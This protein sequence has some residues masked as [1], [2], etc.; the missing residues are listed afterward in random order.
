M[1][2]YETSLVKAQGTYVPMIDN[3]FQKN[4]M[5]LTSYAKQCVM[6]A[7]SEINGLIENSGKTFKDIDPRSLTESLLMVATMQLNPSATP[8]EVYFLTRNKN[9]GDKNNPNWVTQI[10]AGIEGDGNDT[11]LARFG[12]GV[13]TV[14]KFW[15]VREGDDFEYPQYM[16]IEMSP[17]KWRPSGQGKIVRIVYPISKTNGEIE[18]LIAEREDVLINLRAHIS[19]NLMNETFGIAESRYKAN[20]AQKEK[21]NE[22]KQELL[23]KLDGLPLDDV[24]KH[25]D[26][27]K[28]ISP[29]WKDNPEGMIVRKMR[30]N[31]IKKYPK[32]FENSFVNQVYNEATDEGYKAMRK[33]V[34]DNANQQLLD[35]DLT[36]TSAAYDVDP[37][38][39]EVVREP[40]RVQEEPEAEIV[41]AEPKTKPVEKASP[42]K[43]TINDAKDLEQAELFA[44]AV[45]STLPDEAPF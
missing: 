31:A 9:T 33:D 42:T 2:G 29:A 12:R 20:Y 23:S 22:K 34:T 15:E 39:G 6:N 7:V 3:T 21:I 14:H 32:D 44:T 18:Y 1:S 28:A 8:S 26:F 41:E 25:P 27:Q 11:L 37:Q 19:N 36:E 16:G 10:E 40:S 13:K 35:F 5:T 38:T 24:L 4:G 45:K 17:P 43:A 30:N